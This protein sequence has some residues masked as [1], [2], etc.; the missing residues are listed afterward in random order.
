MAL[1]DFEAVVVQMT[2]VIASKPHHGRREL[3]ES[4]ALAIAANTHDESLPELALRAYGVT[5]HEDL[6][7]AARQEDVAAPAATQPRGIPSDHERDSVARVD[8]VT[9]AHRN[10]GDHD[11]SIEHERVCTG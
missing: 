5:L 11:G 9:P 7:R 6:R 4:L 10:E 2:A 8:A 1:V 3:S